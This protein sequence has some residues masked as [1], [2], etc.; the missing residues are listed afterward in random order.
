MNTHW[1]WRQTLQLCMCL[2]VHIINVFFFI[3]K[4]LNLYLTWNDFIKRQLNLQIL[5]NN[6]YQ[7]MY[8]L[9]LLGYKVM[10]IC[11]FTIYIFEIVYWRIN[12]LIKENLILSYNT[13]FHYDLTEINIKKNIF[14]IHDIKYYSFINRLG[15]LA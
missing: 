10:S 11:C 13:I 7:N 12:V 9:V 1:S 15:C 14:H 6:D 4:L 5:I 2:S 8:I 3:A